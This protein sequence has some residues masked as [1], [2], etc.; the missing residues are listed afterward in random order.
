MFNLAVPLL[1][2]SSADR[3]EPFY[4]G[5]LGFRI[6]SVF[7]LDPARS[8]PAYFVLRRDQA[9]LHVS[10]FPGDGQIGHVVNIAISDIDALKRELDANNIDTGGGIMDQDWGDRE[11][12]IRDQDG[13]CLRFQSPKK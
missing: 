4:C 8:D 6:A 1:R 9:V 7:R 13:N 3:V 11:I 10:S 5:A 12:Y 2:V